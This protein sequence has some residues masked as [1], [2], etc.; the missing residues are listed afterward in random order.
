MTEEDPVNGPM[1]SLTERLTRVIV[2]LEEAEARQ[3]VEAALAHLDLRRPLVYGVELRIEKRRGG[4]PDRQALVLAADLDGYSVYEVVVAE[5]GTVVEAVDRP[6]V[7]PAFSQ[8]EIAEATVLARDHP[9]VADVARR[10]GVRPAVF[11]PTRHEDDTET[12]PPRPQR[13]VGVHFLDF[14]DPIDVMPLVSAVVD[15]TG[16]LVASVQ[17]HQAGNGG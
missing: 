13:L 7:V 5:D 1:S 10:W 9:E 17:D 8:E 4:V 6:N 11:Y 12:G 15:L 16:R 14:S 2:P 3:A